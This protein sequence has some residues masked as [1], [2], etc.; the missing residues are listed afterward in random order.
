MGNFNTVMQVAVVLRSPDIEGLGRSFW[1][2]IPGR[3]VAM[4]E[5]LFEIS[6]PS[7]GFARLKR[8]TRVR[9]ESKS[10]DPCVPCLG[11]WMADMEQ[12]WR[13]ID[14]P[15]VLD[16]KDV[17]ASPILK[18]KCIPWDRIRSLTEI[19]LDLREIQANDRKFVFE[20]VDSVL[21]YVTKRCREAKEEMIGTMD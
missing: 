1:S 14:L 6:E 10:R 5:D 8:L 15:N 9:I 13:D 2:H 3:E 12:M 4:C 19:A 17:V 16:E 18:T 7:N 20:A 21:L 11:L